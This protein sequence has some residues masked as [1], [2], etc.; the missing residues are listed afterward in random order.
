[1]QSITRRQIRVALAGVAAVLVAAAALRRQLA[2]AADDASPA[3]LG[4]MRAM[5]Q[6]LRRDAT[7]LEAIAPRLGGTARIPASVE[8][9][10]HAFRGELVRHHN[11]EDEDLWPLLRT[12]LRESSDLHQVDL[13]VDEH[14]QL[15]AS[16]NAVDRG[17]ANHADIAAA[18]GALVRC[19]RDHLDHE[20]RAIFPLLER[21]LSRREWRRFLLTERRRTPPRHR[22]DFLSWVLEDATERDSAAVLDELPPP[23]R[24]VYKRILAPRYAARHR[25]Q[26]EPT[27]AQ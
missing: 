10:W 2:R 5:H 3:D 22:P 26:L 6:A 11:A 8:D 18:A 17:L 4:F 21:H 12:H 20:E 1:M 15:E 9:G 19:L 27:Q 13:M 14:R 7:R 23:G 24:L 16:I 25:W